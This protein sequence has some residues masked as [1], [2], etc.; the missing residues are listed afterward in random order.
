MLRTSKLYS[1]GYPELSMIAFRRAACQTVPTRRWLMKPI[2]I[3]H[4]FVLCENDL[5]D[6]SHATQQTVLRACRI[7][8]PIHQLY[9][10]LCQTAEIR[11][12]MSFSHR[13]DDLHVCFKFDP[14]LRP[15]SLFYVK[16]PYVKAF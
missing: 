3:L 8:H 2:L 16:R 6:A 12:S 9:N 14:M 5:A 10:D 4:G 11:S 7:P 13:S 15:V 1:S